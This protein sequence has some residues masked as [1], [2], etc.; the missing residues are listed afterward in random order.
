MAV[1]RETTGIL[2]RAETLLRSGEIGSSMVR[3]SGR[4]GTPIA[5]LEPG[6]GLH[7]WFVPVA[8]GNRLA[9]FLQLLPDLTMMRYSSF[10]RRDDSMEGCPPEESW[11]DAETVRR[12]ARESARPGETLGEPFLTY[13]QAPS[14]LAWAVPLTSPDGATRT[15][16]VAGRAVWEA[17]PPNRA[18][19][20]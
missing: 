18:G 8:I 20:G 3:K 12:R 13:D 1:G 2:A 16:H 17:P 14:R 6:G 5:V 9:G 7:S 4:I 11:I 10:Q 15:L 19:D